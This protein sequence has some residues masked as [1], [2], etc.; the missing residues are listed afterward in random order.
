VVIL[1]IQAA[2]VIVWVDGGWGVDALVAAETRPHK[3]LDLIVAEP[4][5]Q[6]LHG[7]LEHIGFRLVTG[8]VVAG[9]YSDS[10]DRRVDVTTV[11]F[12]EHGRARSRAKTGEH[13]YEPGALDGRGEIGGV[14]VACLSAAAQMQAH[15]G[16]SPV[17]WTATTST[18]FIRGSDSSYRPTTDDSP[19]RRG[20]DGRRSRSQRA[21]YGRVSD[22][23]RL[24]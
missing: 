15:T 20:A 17:A 1:S 19:R 16:N 8:D 5:A 24:G 14:V 3:D 12:D 22:R 13:I 10:A 18:F 11:A 4:D 23:S 9:L 2:G 21:T 7:V 6:A